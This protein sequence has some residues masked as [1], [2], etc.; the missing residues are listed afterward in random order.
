M[1]RRIL[2]SAMVTAAAALALFAP[3]SLR[4]EDEQQILGTFL[5]GS[6][7][8]PIEEL[9]GRVEIVRDPR[10]RSGW[11]VELFVANT[12]D[13]PQRAQVTVAVQRWISNPMARTSGMPAD[14]FARVV[15]IELAPYAKTTR[16]LD[17]PAAVAAEIDQSNVLAHS[18]ARAVERARE[19]G[20]EPPAWASGAEAS[21]RRSFVAELRPPPRSVRPRAG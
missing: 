18:R 6:G 9:V 11:A 1:V 10:A 7:D 15:S 19:R 17:L 3:R 20:E 21:P 5:I 12:S 14:V 16:T 13:E 2:G 4:A 8:T